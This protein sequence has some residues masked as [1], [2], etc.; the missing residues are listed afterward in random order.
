MRIV[1]LAVVLGI[2]FLG[3]AQTTPVPIQMI[4]ENPPPPGPRPGVLQGVTADTITVSQDVLRGMAELEPDISARDEAPQP[5]VVMVRV[6]VSK[7]GAVEEVVAVAGQG[8]LPAVAVAGVKNWKYRPYMVDGQPREVQSA[9]TISFRDG[10]GKRMN[11]GGTGVA[12]MAGMVGGV[13][14]GIGSSPVVL[15]PAPP[16]TVRVSSGVVQG[17]AIAQPQPVYPPIAKAA[18][19]QG[20]VVMHA[21]ISKTGDIEDLQTISGPPM[22]TGAA[23]D[24]VKQWKYKPYLLAGQP[25]E[26]ETT[27]NVNFLFA[28]SPRPDTGTTL[29]AGSLAPVGAATADGAVFVSSGVMTR[30]QLASPQ[31]TCSAPVEPGAFGVV[32]LRAIIS[33]E[34]A[35]KDVQVVSAAKSLQQC[36]LD[37]VRQWRYRPY[38][39]DGV[40]KEVETM[41]VLSL[42]VG[43][44]AALPVGAK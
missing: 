9:V 39:V 5:G 35:M 18:H 34:G 31:P 28:E 26:V 24:A 10:V 30:Y 13:M 3:M 37:A 38:L 12:G 8:E 29:P 43:G 21:V 11:V 16:G 40:P 27:I 36:S 2:S 23:M 44:P 22:L 42:S 4:K 25:V 15:R 14:G 19:V 1:A 6:L 7:T 41:V 33:T 17:L 20:V 32:V